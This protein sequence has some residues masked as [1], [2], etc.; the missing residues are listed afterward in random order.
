MKKLL[1]L[2][3]FGT[4]VSGLQAQ[5]PFIG[6]QSDK[7]TGVAVHEFSASATVVTL[8]Q[9]GKLDSLWIGKNG[10][11]GVSEDTLTATPTTR[12]NNLEIGFDF[13][14]AGKTM[15]YYG[16]TA[17]GMVFFGERDSLAPAVNINNQVDT[18]SAD[19]VHFLLSCYNSTTVQGQIRWKSYPLKAGE[20][21]YVR[22]ET[23]QDTLFIGYENLQGVDKF[24]NTLTFSFQYAFDKNGKL[25]FRPVS[26][27]P[28]VAHNASTG[29]YY[30]VYTWGLVGKPGM[31]TSDLL[32]IKADG[33]SQTSRTY[34]EITQTSHPLAG[35]SYTFFPPAPCAAVA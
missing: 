26:M 1:L 28:Q 11:T 22:Y 7:T 21:A 3:V 5:N 13:P 19:Y 18:K 29:A 12:R 2:A 8:T 10:L 33:T 15:K 9:G 25:S 17:G 23:V 24:G 35:E 30:W 20:N 32:Y 6:Y 27:E 34:L 4:L 16:L 31:L 14:F